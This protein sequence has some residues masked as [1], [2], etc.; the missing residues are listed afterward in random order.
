MGKLYPPHPT[1]VHQVALALGPAPGYPSWRGG[2][3]SLRYLLPG[4]VNKARPFL[5]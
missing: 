5:G 2:T 4:P 3:L 1:L